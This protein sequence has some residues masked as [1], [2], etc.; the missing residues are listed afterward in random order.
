MQVRAT[1]TTFQAV[2]DISKDP[3][4]PLSVSGTITFTQEDP[5]GPT[6]IFGTITGLEANVQRGLHIQ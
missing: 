1:N 2:V 4:S 5:E 6:R 3:T